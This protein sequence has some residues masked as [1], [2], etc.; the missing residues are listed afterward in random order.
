MALCRALAETG[1]RRPPVPRETDDV[2]SSAEPL[3]SACLGST[4]VAFASA[5]ETGAPAAVVAP[6]S[7]F[8]E[9][10]GA[11]DAFPLRE[12]AV[13]DFEDAPVAAPVL[14]RAPLGDDDL[15]SSGWGAL[16]PEL[17][18]SD[19]TRPDRPVRESLLSVAPDAF[20]AAVSAA[21]V[22]SDSAAA[23]PACGASAPPALFLW[24]LDSEDGFSTGALG[25]RAPR[26]LPSP[27]LRSAMDNTPL[28]DDPDS[29]RSI[30]RDARVSRGTARSSGPHCDRSG[31]AGRAPVAKAWSSRAFHV[32]HRAPMGVLSASEAD[33]I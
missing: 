11:V 27:L 12:A 26:P 22:D 1:R 9:D 18:A 32:K 16:V 14:E 21:T 2:V 8:F 31:L 17:P 29:L 23:L 30:D 5:S 25:I 28:L 33:C 19:L 4:A 10:L 13:P 15:D 7:F 24:T 20:T 6:L 3:D